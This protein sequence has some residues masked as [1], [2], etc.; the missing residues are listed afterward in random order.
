[1]SKTKSEVVAEAH[2]RINV[3]SVDEDPSADMIAYA[4]DGADALLAE[5][6][7]PPHNMPLYWSIE[8]VP[9]R[10]WRP[11]S[12]LLAVDL[13]AHYEVPPREPRSRAVMRLR[14]AV[15]TDDRTDRRDTDGDGIV[16]EAEEQA[17]RRASF[18]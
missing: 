6:T 17:G 3:L 8:G 18:Y 2:R 9:D 11:F 15:F 12:W 14:E 5:L 1:M 10:L 7:G 16:S 13:A 4:G